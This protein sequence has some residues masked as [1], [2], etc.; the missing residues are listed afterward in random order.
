MKQSAYIPYEKFNL[1]FCFMS[2]Y[3]TGREPGWLNGLGS[4]IT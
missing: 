2:L 4:W 1:Q 3:N